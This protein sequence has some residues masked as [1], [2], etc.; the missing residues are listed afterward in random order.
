MSVPYSSNLLPLNEYPDERDI[1]QSVRARNA[2]IEA[3]RQ[4]SINQDPVDSILEYQ[5]VGAV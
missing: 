2:I 4:Q 1:R 3:I 5:S